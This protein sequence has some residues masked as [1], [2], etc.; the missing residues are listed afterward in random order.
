MMSMLS[1]V[2]IRRHGSILFALLRIRASFQFLHTSIHL[3][4]LLILWPLCF[5]IWTVC[6]DRCTC[7]TLA[8]M[9]MW[10]IFTHCL[11]QITHC[12]FSPVLQKDHTN[13]LWGGCFCFFCFY[14]RFE[15]RKRIHGVNK[16]FRVFSLKVFICL[17][18]EGA[19]LRVL[20]LHEWK[21]A[22][23]ML[24]LSR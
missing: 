14:I 12:K 4:H 16:S 6:I 5:W 23:W 17:F 15:V 10:R 9:C 11:F 18:P 3:L 20:Y 21:V 19:T 8:C 24:C 7:N 1:F 2:H 22:K 13:V